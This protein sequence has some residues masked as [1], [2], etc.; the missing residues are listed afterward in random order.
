MLHIELNRATGHE[1]RIAALSN[2]CEAFDHGDEFF[3]NAELF[4]GAAQA[5][6]KMLG[7]SNNDDEIRMILSALEMVFRGTPQ[8][9]HDAYDRIGTGLPHHLLRIV[10]RCESGSI[11]NPVISIQN[12]WRILLYI[13]RCQQA[14]PGLCRIR[15]IL[16]AIARAS[17]LSDF[18]DVRMSRIRLIANLANCDS[19][20]VLVYE[21]DDILECILRTAH[22]DETDQVRHHAAVALS[23]LASA[24]AN[25]RSMA[26]NDKLLGCLVKMILVEKNAGTK[27][28]VIK[29]VQTLAFAKE[30]R[31]RLVTFK[32]GVVLEAMKKSLLNDDKDPRPRIRAAG[33]LTN[34]ACDE[35]SSYIGE[36]KGML[37][38]LVIAATKDINEDVQKRACLALAKV[39]NGITSR[40]ACFETLLDALVAASL[41]KVENNISGVFRVKAR[42]PEN[43]ESL[44][45]HPGVLDTLCDICLCDTALV[46][47]RDNAVRAI[48]HLVNEDSN[49]K[50]MCT[51][52]VLNALVAAAGWKDPDLQDARDSAVRAM[53]RLA[54][55]IS[56]RSIMARHPGL[57]VV[58]SKAVEREAEWE[59][60]GMKSDYGF[61]AKPLLMTLLLAM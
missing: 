61:L 22:L 23:E 37:E 18:P 10:S 17:E 44:V 13:S 27:D 31:V 30:N 16:P 26:A 8:S 54:T 48:M 40:M 19:N 53:E 2:A 43:R 9:V 15:G 33:A 32:N 25:Q 1:R 14:R 47:D 39:A 5:L 3:H 24:S 34:L 21:N 11:A 29:A 58:V 49:R 36:Q 51:R 4:H 56:N 50:V 57:L 52:A 20:K 12:T 28:A 6:S 55:D 59:E 42:D 38:T 35:T 41:T 60:E 46:A 7:Y 45:R